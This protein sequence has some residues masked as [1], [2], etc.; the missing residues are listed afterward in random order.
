MRQ[1]ARRALLRGGLCAAIWSRAPR[2]GAQSAAPDAYRLLSAA[3]GEAQILAP[4]A[5]KTKLL[6]FNGVSPGPLL[7]LRHGETLKLRLTNGLQQPTCLSFPGLR[8]PNANAG[9]AGLTQAPLTPGASADLVFSPPDSGFNLYAPHVGANDAEQFQRGLYGPIIVD[10]PTPPAI[11][12]ESVVILT[13]WRLD[14]QAQIKDDFGDAALA[15]GAGRI[16][17]LLGAN[18]APAPLEQVVA[19]GARVRLR[20]AN[21]ASARILW[22]VID[23]AKPLIIAI[24]GQ[25]SESF[26]PL[27]NLIPLGPGARFDMLFDMPRD[28]GALARFTLR[29]ADTGAL[30]GEADQI[31]LQFRASGDARAARSALV[32]LPANPALPREIDLAG[33]HRADLIIGGGAGSRFSVN[34]TSFVDWAPKPFIAVPRGAPVSL[35]FVNKTAVTQ[36]LRLGGHVA[37]L[38]HGLDDGWEP[39]WRD[40]ILVAPGKTARIAFVADNP[41]KWPIESSI[42]EHRQAGVGGWMQVG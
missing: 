41:G 36:A 8:L 32:G 6:A 15:Q 11:D 9:I 26:E 14:A 28:A 35:G 38:L 21:G 17:A 7:R 20:V 23:G 27:R 2:L 22:L 3:P 29:G 34:G 19:P 13:D 4:P 33:A 24:D 40:I 37:R 25:P 10:E 18:G 39:Y 5:P 31:L 1:I 12:F 30:A 42:P 16:G